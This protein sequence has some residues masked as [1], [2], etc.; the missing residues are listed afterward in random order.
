MPALTYAKGV[1]L[2]KV[3][4]GGNDTGVVYENDTSGRGKYVRINNGVWVSGYLAINNKG[5]SQ[6]D[7]TLGNLPYPVEAGSYFMGSCH[8][9]QGFHARWDLSQ[10]CLEASSDYGDKCYL[11]AKKP[12]E[13][14]GWHY[15]THEDVDASDLMIL[16]F[17]LHYVTP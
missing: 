10:F 7:F 4:F 14:P 11:A 6:G 5:T 1:F 9:A 16:G 15:V 3:Y 12:N 17:D 13:F 8:E 2:P